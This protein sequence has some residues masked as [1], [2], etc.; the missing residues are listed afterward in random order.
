MRD[1]CRP[2]DRPDR[3][4]PEYDVIYKALLAADNVSLSVNSQFAA[5]RFADWLGIDPGRIAV[6][7]NGVTALPM[8]GDTTAQ[9]RF[10]RFDAR[11]APSSLTLGTV[12]RLDPNKRPLLWIDAAAK[13]LAGAARCKVHSGR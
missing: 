8:V 6:I 5:S 9:A 13:I 12:M 1:R 4:R 10:E 7:R 2:I 3:Y 11:T